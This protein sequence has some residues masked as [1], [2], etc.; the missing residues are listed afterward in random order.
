MKPSLLLLFLI[1]ANFMQPAVAE[2]APLMKFEWIKNHKGQM[3]CYALTPEGKFIFPNNVSS[4]HCDHLPAPVRY[5]WSVSEEDRPACYA[6]STKDGT[7]LLNGKSVS[8]SF[9]KGQPD[10]IRYVRD[11]DEGTQRCFAVFKA[12]GHRLFHGSPVLDAFCKK[13]DSL[14]TSPTAAQDDSGRG[15]VEKEKA[16]PMVDE[17]NFGVIKA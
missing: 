8:D 17:K 3:A 10:P 2:D 13:S 4:K 1:F 11:E 15:Q 12:N 6:V 14:E 16:S 5:E 7:Y 9:C